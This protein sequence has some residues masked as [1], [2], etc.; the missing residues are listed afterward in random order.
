[1]KEKKF[2]LFYKVLLN[3]TSFNYCDPKQKYLVVFHKH[4]I[5]YS[6]IYSYSYIYFLKV[7]LER[8][9]YLYNFV[10]A[11]FFCIFLSMKQFLKEWETCAWFCFFWFSQRVFSLQH[12]LAWTSKLF[13]RITKPK[14]VNNKPFDITITKY[15]LH[16]LLAFTV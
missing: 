2:H 7:K 14:H 5:I 13:L 8:D 6:Y 9:L 15:T 11:N 4:K 12:F 3:K 10:F 16:V 1:M